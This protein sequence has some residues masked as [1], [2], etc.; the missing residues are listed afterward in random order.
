MRIES[1]N[2]ATADPVPV[3]RIGVGSKAI[4]QA[5][6]DQDKEIAQSHQTV[7][8]DKPTSEETSTAV[9][10]INREVEQINDQLSALNRSIR[11]SVD[12]STHDIVVRVVD[13]ESG[14]VIKE[15]PPENILKLRER[16]KELSG[17][18]VEEEA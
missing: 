12:D 18:M 17:L 13:K 8:K 9:E 14:E 16:M 7:Q 10:E 2:T 4:A 6:T 15:L 3:G 1:V 11:F 5:S